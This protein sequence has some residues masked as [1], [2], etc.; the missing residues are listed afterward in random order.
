MARDDPFDFSKL[1]DDLEV[2]V[3]YPLHAGQLPDEPRSTMSG[4]GR[5]QEIQV[6]A[7]LHPPVGTR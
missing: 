4:D 5:G 7:G 2:R 6:W 3:V 1:V